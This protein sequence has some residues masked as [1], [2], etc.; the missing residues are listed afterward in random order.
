MLTPD[1]SLC[2][3]ILAHV[4]L[5]RRHD[6]HSLLLTSKSFHT[7]AEELVYHHIIFTDVRR[8]RLFVASLTNA[9]RLAGLVHTFGINLSELRMRAQIHRQE[10]LNVQTVLRREFWEAVKTVLGAM[11]ALENLVLVQI[12]GLRMN[13]TWMLSQDDE[14]P[15]ALKEIKFNLA[16]DNHIARFLNAQGAKGRLHAVQLYNMAVPRISDA[17]LSLDPTAANSVDGTEDGNGGGGIEDIRLPVVEVLD[18]SLSIT[19]HISASSL[20]PR[21]AHLQLYVD[22]HTT[23]V[24]VL[25]DALLH[26]LSASSTSA[27]ARGVRKIRGLSLVEVPI[28]LS[29]PLLA[30]L[31]QSDALS[32][33]TST[34]HH[35]SHFHLPRPYPQIQTQSSRSRLPNSRSHSHS[36][37]HTQNANQ[38]PLDESPNI[39]E[40]LDFLHTLT[41]FHSLHSL[42]LSLSSW[43]F[44]DTSH[45]TIHNFGFHAP[46][47]PPRTIHTSSV[48]QQAPGTVPS[49][50]TQKVWLAELKMYC[51]SLRIVVF[52]LGKVR[53]RWIYHH[54]Y[55]SGDPSEDGHHLN[56]GEAPEVLFNDMVPS[57]EL[58][59]EEDGVVQERTREEGEGGGGGSGGG[60]SGVVKQRTGGAS[61]IR[62]D[63][64]PPKLQNAVVPGEWHYRMD[65]NQWPGHS[66]LWSTC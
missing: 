33:L 12:P 47:P 44:F 26:L 53:F 29:T 32:N 41:S 63:C 11:T 19:P 22:V 62:V 58:Q 13:F 20:N 24:G 16:F 30:Q 42:E 4:P 28:S 37:S 39:S 51:P 64:G 36:H 48:V 6:L 55:Y 2:K 27:N 38:S 3:L 60:G 40:K 46:H 21:L 50:T 7:A 61:T 65:G 5:Y 14:F 66:T 10:A 43:D 56:G 52:W 57:W 31:A 25:V 59:P 8:I 35:L 54:A 15:F 18:I 34:L 23:Q 17:L 1:H 9:P 45:T 49:P